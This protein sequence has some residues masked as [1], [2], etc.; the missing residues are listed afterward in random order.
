MENI[1]VIFY[2]LLLPHQNIADSH[3]QTLRA[4]QQRTGLLGNLDP[5][6]VMGALQ[7]G[8][9]TANPQAESVAIFHRNGHGGE[10]DLSAGADGETRSGL[11]EDPDLRFEVLPEEEWEAKLNEILSG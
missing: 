5:F 10:D 11:T 9:S 8:D 3:L 6:E 1:T 7:N 4:D 2:T